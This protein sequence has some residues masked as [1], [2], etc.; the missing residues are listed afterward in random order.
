MS[1]DIKKWATQLAREESGGL[2]GH[3]ALRLAQG[4]GGT[5]RHQDN[6]KRVNSF[7]EV[8]LRQSTG[9]PQPE[10]DLGHSVIRVKWPTICSTAQG[11]RFISAHGYLLLEKLY[12][13]KVFPQFALKK[14]LISLGESD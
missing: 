13:I 2:N 5:R 7:V 10:V 4:Y 12:I 8:F 1:W 3:S 6:G 9:K 14:R 11:N